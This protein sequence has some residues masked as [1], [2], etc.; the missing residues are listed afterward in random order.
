MTSV[1]FPRTHI[2]NPEV[3]VHICSPQTPTRRHEV[4][5]EESPRSSQVSELSKQNLRNKRDPASNNRG[6]NQVLWPTA[7]HRCIRVTKVT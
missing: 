1:R 4:K 3:V 2:K 6:G 7:G 5:T